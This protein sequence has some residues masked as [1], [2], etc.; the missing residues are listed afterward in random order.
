MID[1]RW[2]CSCPCPL[3]NEAMAK[4]LEPYRQQPITMGVPDHLT[5]QNCCHRS[6]RVRAR[7]SMLLT[8]HLPR[9]ITTTIIT[10]NIQFLSS[11]SRLYLDCEAHFSRRP[12]EP[13]DS[14]TIESF[15]S[16]LPAN[17]PQTFYPIL[18]YPSNFLPSMRYLSIPPPLWDLIWPNISCFFLIP[19]SHSIL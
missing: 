3:M 11:S 5:V 2:L 18:S 16:C 15:L 19:N 6:F 4:L 13:G 8:L 7:V 14:S 9:R 17:N 10:T 12:S 1:C